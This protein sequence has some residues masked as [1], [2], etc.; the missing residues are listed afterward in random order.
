MDELWSCAEMADADRRVGESGLPGACLMAAAGA[1]VA[2]AVLARWPLARRVLVLAGPGNNG[3][4][5]Y[6]AARLLAQRGL[7]VTVAGTPPER[8]RGDAAEAA[9]QWTGGV[10][11]LASADLGAAD[12]VVDALFG[13]GLARPLSGDAAEVVER[14]NAASLPVLAVD[15]P[16]GLDG[17]RGVSSGGPV[18]KADATVTF[19]RLKPGHLLLPGRALCGAVTVADIG[20]PD[21]VVD[22]L[23]VRTFRNAPSLWRAVFPAP[24]AEGHK[25]AR[26]HALVWSGAEFST[27]AARLSATAA[28][29]AGAGAVT[30][31]GPEAALRIHAAHVTAV[32]LKPAD[33]AAAVSGLLGERRYAAAVVG[34]GAGEGVEPIAAALLGGAG[35]CVLDADVFSAFAG[36]ADALAALIAERPGRGVVLTPHAGEFDRLF[37]DKALDGSKLERGRAAAARFGAVVVMKG[38]DT[39]VASPDGRAAIADN[40]PPYLA[41]AGAG[42]VLAGFCAGL[43]AQGMP[44]FEAAAAAVWLHGEAAKQI[45]RGLIADDLAD[46]LPAVLARLGD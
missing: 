29:R 2:D 6:A 14:L 22:A 30:L 32:M 37:G 13:A 5:G 21:G 28:L 17:D 25:Y 27:G 31:V 16:S 12:V 41:T 11:S 43:L 44:A 19:V 46:A 34:P 9:A 35:A 4:D 39:V 40:A 23:G 36:R 38:G 8:L 33:D 42:D 18:V 7:D 1:A 20:M 45:G 10:S 3:G 26:G 15:V 24:R